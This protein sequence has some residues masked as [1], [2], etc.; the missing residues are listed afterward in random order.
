MDHSSII[1][2]PY[3]VQ[4]GLVDEILNDIGS[5]TKYDLGL[6]RRVKLVEKDVELLYPKL[7]TIPI[8]EKIVR[9]LIEGESEYLL[10]MGDNISNIIAGIKGKFSFRDGKASATGLRKKYQKDDISFE[11]IFHSTDTN[12]ESD[13]IGEKLFGNDFRIAKG[14]QK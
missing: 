13:E 3:S 5:V 2:T 12:Q 10:V 6:R 1:C 8:F 4:N 7:I 9:C 14:I 11:F